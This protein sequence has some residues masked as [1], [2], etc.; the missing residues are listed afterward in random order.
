[1]HELRLVREVFEDI[2]RRAE[3]EGMQKV[4]RVYL[5]VGGFTEIDPEILRHFFAECARGTILEGAEVTVEESPARELRLLG[6]E[7][8]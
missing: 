8:E 3:E 4:T 7:G 1:M 5:R 2:L 6:F